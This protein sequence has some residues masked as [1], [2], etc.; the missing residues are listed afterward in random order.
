MRLRLNR[1]KIFFTTI[2][3][4]LIILSC[5]NYDISPDD[6]RLQEPANNIV[7]NF[8]KYLAS[9]G[10]GFGSDYPRIIYHSVDLDAGEN[11]GKF[12]FNLILEVREEYE[13][14]TVFEV[15]PNGCANPFEVKNAIQTVPF[16]SANL[17]KFGPGNFY[18]TIQAYSGTFVTVAG[19]N[20]N[21]TYSLYDHNIRHLIA[22]EQLELN[23]NA[24]DSDDKI[25]A[26]SGFSVSGQTIPNLCVEL[27]LNNEV[28]DRFSDPVASDWDYKIDAGLPLGQHSIEVLAKNVAQYS[29]QK[30]FDVIER[31][32]VIAED[33]P[34][35][36]PEIDESYH[37][38]P[39]D[40]FINSNCTWYAAAAVKTAS[41]GKI[42]PS[43]WGNAYEWHNNAIGKPG[44]K[45]INKFPQAG[46]VLEFD[47]GKCTNKKTG[48]KFPCGHVVFIE[49][50]E[51][52]G[53]KKVKLTWSEEHANLYESGWPNAELV[54]PL[55]EESV[56]RHR[57]YQE[58]T[59][60][61]KGEI[62]NYQGKPIYFIHFDY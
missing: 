21:E 46:S 55:E 4:L 25:Y 20:D 11:D 45:S 52:I 8:D 43:K 1:K 60:N 15:V 28:V 24:I 47:L 32:F 39:G 53:D 29:D 57:V 49:S 35:F 38:N 31:S 36:D 27:K 42:V 50:V 34:A 61:S 18:I 22:A 16:D 2:I 23:I 7:V 13:Y 37:R 10:S 30:N 54:K 6:E 3:L 5:V 48:E 33:V 62:N 56:Y 59:L 26:G 9:V 58:F 17:D 14:I 12:A 44:V 19:T 41:D 40:T 51:F